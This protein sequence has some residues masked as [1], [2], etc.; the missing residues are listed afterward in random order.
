[1]EYMIET[2]NLTKRY[3][4]VSVVDHINM[5]VPKRKI[6]G[7]LGRNGAG[8]TTAMKMM[9]RL[10]YPTEGIVRLFGHDYQDGSKAPYEKM[11]SIIE[12]PGFYSNLTGYENLKI[13]SM[14][15]R[16]SEK[17]IQEALRVVGLEK[18]TKKVFSDYSLGM[19]QRLG[20]AAAI[21]HQPELLILDEPING[22]DPIGIS[23]IRSFLLELSHEK[24]TTILI[25]S[26]VLN[27]IEQTADIIG[28]MQKGRLI[29]EVNMAE[30][31]K[32][33]RKY[34]EY[35]VSDVK[36]ASKLLEKKFQITEFT[37]EHNRIKIYDFS[38]NAGNIN[39]VLVENGLI[40]SKINECEENLEEY[41][42]SLIGG[43][44]IA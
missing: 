2:Q 32:R 25:S 12:T 6:Y 43:G 28:V 15:R 14:L 29:E 13:I 18:E 9:L 8:K 22:L 7:L 41:F 17:N 42:S 10:V 20:I 44:S 33:N 4:T 23:E 27:E 11:G 3:G 40:V 21:M 30:L 24:G 1:M 37:A 31:H 16:G 36:Q 26:H 34:L 35:E 5:H 19:K 39:K 38:H